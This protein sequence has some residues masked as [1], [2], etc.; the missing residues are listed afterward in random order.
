MKES[1]FWTPGAP[2]IL[3]A[4]LVGLLALHVFGDGYEPWENLVA[5]LMCAPPLLIATLFQMS[6]VRRLETRTDP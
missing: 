4:L 1:S 3:F 6:W 5:L 2:G